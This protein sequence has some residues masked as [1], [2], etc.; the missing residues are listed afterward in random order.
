MGLPYGYACRLQAFSQTKSMLL[1][2]LA[3]LDAWWNGR[4]EIEVDGLYKAYILTHVVIPRRAREFYP[5]ANSLFT[6]RQSGSILKR[7]WMQPYLPFC[8]YRGEKLMTGEH[9][10]KHL[11]CSCPLT[12]IWFRSV[13]MN[14]L[15]NR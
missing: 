4:D 13:R 8:P 7:R 14:Q 11:S 12:A 6:I 5:R 10:W 9:L 15:W 2:H 3:H 1:E